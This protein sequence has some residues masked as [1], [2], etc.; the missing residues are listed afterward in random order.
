MVR[1]VTQE[2]WGHIERPPNSV[3]STEYI[4]HNLSLI[5]G[6]GESLF[7]LGL[8]PLCHAMYA[9][10]GIVVQFLQDM[11]LKYI[12]HD[13]TVTVNQHL[14][15]HNHGH[16]HRHGHSLCPAAMPAFCAF[17]AGRDYCQRHRGFLST[18]SMCRS[19][20]V[21]TARVQI[22][23]VTLKGFKATLIVP[24]A[25]ARYTLVCLK[26]GICQPVG[27]ID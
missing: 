6:Q 19:L 16:G 9:Q 21:R 24:L 13:L 20:H 1:L 14:N 2:I 3:H 25:T 5:Y 23:P 7:L 4:T 15:S 22:P 8:L 11:L 12:S 26:K 18:V 27:P 10:G 17:Y